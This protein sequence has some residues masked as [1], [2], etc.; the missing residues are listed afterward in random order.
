L[1]GKR[2]KVFSVIK[3]LFLSVLVI[4]GAYLLVLTGIV[5]WAFEVKLQEWPQFVF[6]EPFRVEKG[7]NIETLRL[8]Q[9][10][11]RLGYEKSVGLV[12]GPGQWLQVGSDL[13]IFLKPF[14][15]AGHG[16]VTGPISIRLDW[17]IV[18]SISLLRSS[19]EVD[20]VLLE[21]ELLSVIPRSGRPPELCRP[22]K[23][24]AIDPLLKEAVI[25]TED[26]RF[27]SHYGIDPIS[28][29][30]AFKVNWRAGRY[31]LGGSTIPQQLIKM[32]LLSS[33]KTLW[34][35]FNEILLAV[36]ADTIYSKDRILE[37]YLNR[38]YLGHCGKFPVKGVAEASRLF[39]SKDPSD[40]EPGECALLAAS[41]MAP[42]IINPHRHPEKARARRNMVLGKLLKTG[43]ISRQ[44]Y[45]RAL[46]TPV[47]MR[48]HA[49]GS[50]EAE[51]FLRLVRERW[52]TIAPGTLGN[53]R[54]M[55]C[56]TSLDPIAQLEALE[57]LRR[58]NGNEKKT[59]LILA[60][61]LKGT[62][63][64]YIAPDVNHWSGKGGNLEVLA[65][66][67]VIPAFVPEEQNR[68]RYT[69]TSPVFFPKQP[70][71]PVT[72]REAFQNHRSMLIFG[73]V[74]SLGADKIAT[75]LKD[76]EIPFTQSG[77]GGV[78]V[79]PM[80]PLQMARAYSLLATLGDAADLGPGLKLIGAAAPAVSHARRS[81]P[82]DPAVLFLVNHMLK[83][84]TRA[85]TRV[86]GPDISW[87]EPSFF[88]A[89]D[90]GG[91]WTI[92]YL[93]DALLVMRTAARN[94]NEQKM[95]NI[96]SLLLPRPAFRSHNPYPAPAAIIYRKICVDSGLRATSICSE[97]IREPYLKGTQPL[98]WCPLT[99]HKSGK[100]RRREN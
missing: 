30:Y 76:F 100:E 21:P 6:S 68:V 74:D 44:E 61:P 90:N 26:A 58:L 3:R 10:L 95:R 86:R 40:L 78:T 57:N 79:G 94:L 20:R 91:V 4:G 73:L 77:T 18:R 17:K 96:S 59:H 93:P 64:A 47:R 67:V 9:R 41:L 75:V 66:L 16:I 46:E 62:V 28:L 63:K 33:K 22:T 37:A 80:S 85:A 50:V 71:V 83:G 32:T 42:N 99:S 38:V 84:L 23:L 53:G 25:L 45:D 88:V 48:R 13:R 98:E 8:T 39:F 24:E 34:R 19:E 55:D 56:L 51:A 97:V 49:P 27:Y 69:L 82:L 7:D 65:P 2:R 31:V 35:K 89:R 12:P 70:G 36:V 14:P 81:I 43:K 60:N 52:R 87:T 29:K 11:A 1:P 72:F 15:I 54:P 5:L 92:A